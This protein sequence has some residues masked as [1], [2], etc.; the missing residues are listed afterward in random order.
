ML[1]ELSG[2]IHKWALVS[3]TKCNPVN[4]SPKTGRD[5]CLTQ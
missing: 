5:L 3:A 1:T 2:P 4:A